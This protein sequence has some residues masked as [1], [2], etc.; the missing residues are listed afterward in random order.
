MIIM[1]VIFIVTPDEP[2]ATTAYLTEDQMA[3]C[4]IHVSWTLPINVNYTDVMYFVV[5]INGMIERIVNTT[6]KPLI[7]TYFSV[8]SCDPRRVGVSAVNHC[9]IM[10]PS[11]KDILVHPEHLEEDC[12]PN[13]NGIN[14]ERECKCMVH[15]YHCLPNYVELFYYY[16]SINSRNNHSLNSH[17]Y[18]DLYYIINNDT[19]LCSHN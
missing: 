5:L 9:D 2:Q 17:D 3:R 4:R 1:I 14:P 12:R 10:G 13:P 8:C 19:S 7:S 6:N 11:S 18:R 16:R 15:R